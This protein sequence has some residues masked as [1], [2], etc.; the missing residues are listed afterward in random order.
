MCGRYIKKIS[1]SLSSSVKNYFFDTPQARNAKK[2][3]EKVLKKC[4]PI[5][6]S[7]LMKMT[8]FPFGPKIM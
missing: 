7:N 3:F 2:K 1:D 6:K 8:L 5:K 4:V